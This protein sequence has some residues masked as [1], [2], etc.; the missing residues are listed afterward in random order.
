MVE[1]NLSSSV[2]GT[3]KFYSSIAVHFSLYTLIFDI[4]TPLAGCPHLN[5]SDWC[6]L[7]PL[8]WFILPSS[9]Y[10]LINQSHGNNS[11][12]NSP[13][14][15]NEP[16]AP[17]RGHGN[18]DGSLPTRKGSLCHLDQRH[19]LPWACL[20]Q[21]AR[22][23]SEGGDLP[24]LLPGGDPLRNH[25]AHHRRA[26]PSGLWPIPLLTHNALAPRLLDQ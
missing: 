9:S 8:I 20:T 6:L 21:K 2:K 1:R 4:F 14:P 25:L 11:N 5:L 15:A 3:N 22:D 23:E 10:K 18:C 24:K 7:V 17:A 26:P 16:A 13:T 12:Q 19:A